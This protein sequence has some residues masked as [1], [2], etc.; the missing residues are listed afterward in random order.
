MRD[1]DHVNSCFC[2]LTKIHEVGKFVN[3]QLKYINNMIYKL[4]PLPSFCKVGKS[5]SSWSQVGDLQ[6]CQLREFILFKRKN[7]CSHVQKATF[8]RAFSS[9]VGAHS[10]NKISKF[11]YSREIM[12]KGKVHLSIPLLGCRL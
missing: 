2:A 11:N 3:H 4:F 6:T 10:V 1:F 5:S 12:L 7:D 8:Q 9:T